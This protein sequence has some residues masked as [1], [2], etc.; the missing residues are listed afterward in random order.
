VLQISVRTTAELC[1]SACDG[2]SLE[3]RA[4]SR[5]TT[6]K[7]G[8]MQHDIGIISRPGQPSQRSCGLITGLV[9]IRRAGDLLAMITMACS[10]SLFRLSADAITPLGEDGIQGVT[11][12]YCRGVQPRQRDDPLFTST[13]GLPVRILLIFPHNQFAHYGEFPEA[14]PKMSRERSRLGYKTSQMKSCGLTSCRNDCGLDGSLKVF[15][16]K[17]VAERSRGVDEGID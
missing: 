17:R 2:G 10:S 16:R 8:A 4:M 15:G 3:P 6:L 9:A 13:H 5:P 7:S 14:V 1:R 12:S 11:Q